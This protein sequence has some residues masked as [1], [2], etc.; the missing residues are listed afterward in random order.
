M[1]RTLFILLTALALVS[2]VFAAGKAGHVVVVVW[3]GLRPDSVNESNTPTL[4]KL[5]REGVF[6]QNHHAVYQ[7]ATIVNGVAMAT[8]VYPNRSGVLANPEYRP[9]IDPLKRTEIES[10]DAIRKG[11]EISGNHYL[12]VPTL[13]EILRGAGLKTAIAST[14]PVAVLL[15]RFERDRIQLPDDA[16]SEM[17]N[18]KFDA[19]TTHALIESQWKDGVPAF[20][21]LWLSEPDHTQHATGL[22]SNKSL[23]ALKSSDRNLALLL[24]ELE[25]KHARKETDVFVIS[26]HGFSTIARAID[27]VAELKKA[28][29]N[30]VSEFKESPATGDIL[31]VGNGGSFLLYVIEHKKRVTQQVVEFLQQQNWTGVVFTREPMTGTFTLDQVRIDTN[32]APDV[33]VS[34]HWT[35]D[36]NDAGV[37][38]MIVTE[39]SERPGHGAHA[40][41][42]Q[43]DMRATLVAAGPDFRAG[44]VDQLPSGNTDL[45]PTILYLLSVRP[46]QPMDGRVLHEALVSGTTGFPALQLRTLEANREFGKSIWHQYLRVTEFSDAVYFD[47]GNGYAAPK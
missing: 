41:L 38:G 4:F 7:S 39:G 21:L 12:K 16:K 8:G 9:A 1:R 33:V 45:A 31:V 25:T 37:P 11:D 3:D 47:E 19:A 35:I 13:V 2:R 44:M 32:D 14:K 30:A 28:G 10:A 22:G 5:A 42:S 29:F 20:S 23:E 6:F 18:T 34:L 15:D 26:D 36:K 40:S 43:F 24:N 17:P 46:P 27:V